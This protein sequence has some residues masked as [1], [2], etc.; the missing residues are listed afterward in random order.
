MTEDRGRRADNGKPEGRG[1]TTEATTDRDDSCFRSH[2]P[3]N[4]MAEQIRS[5]RELRAYQQM[6]ELQQDIFRMTRSFP[7]EEKY[8]LI[9][10]IRRS[11]RSVGG[12]IAEA[13]AKRKYPAYFVSKLTDADGELQETAHW[14]ST[15]RA[16]DYISA[17]QHDLIQNQL[18]EVGAKLG[19]MMSMPEKFAPQ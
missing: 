8:S 13:W 6:F 18:Q 4:P 15:A 3:N 1:Q 10:Q 14:I 12:N 19:K 11:S 2:Q 17:A 9:D 5:F 7:A 16:C